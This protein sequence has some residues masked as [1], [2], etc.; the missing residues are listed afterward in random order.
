MP[1]QLFTRNSK[2]KKASAYTVNFGIPA[3][4]TCP[5]AKVCKEFC[6]AA[7]GAYSWPVVKAA[8]EWR[9]QQTRKPQFVPMV[10]HDLRRKKKLEAVRIHDSGDFYNEDYLNRWLDIA[11]AMPDKIFYAYTKRIVMLKEYQEWGLVPPNF[12]IIYSLGGSQDRHINLEKDRHSRIF[13][14]LEELEAAGYS[15]ATEDDT[16]AWQ[17][18][19]NKIG[20]VIH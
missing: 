7:K 14:S 15:N 16:V 17:S 11:E 3:L 9:F 19:N 13:D 12:R 10:L 2:L 18:D 4:K 6:Y 8:Y 20:L 5:M 1:T